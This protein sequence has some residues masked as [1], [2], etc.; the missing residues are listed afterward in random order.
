MNLIKKC[1]L[2]HCFSRARCHH[3]PCRPG[4]S[5]C[6]QM[7]TPV[8]Q[9]G[10]DM[11]DWST[12]SQ[13]RSMLSQGTT[14]TINTSTAAIWVS[15]PSITTYQ[16]PVDS[17]CGQDRPILRQRICKR[18]NSTVF[19]RE[20]EATPGRCLEFYETV[21]RASW[22]SPRR[23]GTSAKQGFRLWRTTVATVHVWYDM[24]TQLFCA[25]RYCGLEPR[26]PI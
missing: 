24:H 14:S 21:M 15:W 3:A 10:Q 26:S 16:V 2:S 9:V 11:H 25:D 1:L 13:E 23:V 22:E 19:S 20:N 4:H 6:G 12:G 8:D 18:T 5:Q 7:N 17:R